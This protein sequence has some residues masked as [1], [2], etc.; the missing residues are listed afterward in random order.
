VGVWVREARPPFLT[1]A[2]VPVIVGVVVAWYQTGVFDPLLSLLT[3]VGAVLAQAGANMVNDY[4]DTLSGNDNINR[5]RSQFN[6]GAGLIQAGLITA[7]QV[8]LGALVVLGTAAA[9][10]VYLFTLRGPAVLVLMLVGGLSAYFYTGGPVKLAYHGLGEA[11]I[12]MCFG[13]LLV[14]GAYLVQTGTVSPTAAAASVPVGLLITAVLYINQF[15]D[16]EADEAVGKTHWVVRLGLARA[17]RGLYGL[18]AAAYLWIAAEVVLGL[19]PWPTLIA[20][21]SAPLAAK[22]VSVARLHYQSPVDLRPANAAVIG[23]HLVTG[24]LLSAGFIVAGLLGV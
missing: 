6:G 10:G 15:P 22:A 13:P 5:F 12:G 2:T 20:V 19:A 11:A 21:A 8:Y 1:A 17:L 14:T 7:R 18:L 23:S 16:Y 3:L 24:L 4:F 9:I